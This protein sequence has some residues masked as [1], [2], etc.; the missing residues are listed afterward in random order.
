MKNKRE[1]LNIVK[2]KDL[3]VYKDNM[4]PTVFK[5][6]RK[7]VKHKKSLLAEV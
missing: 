4:R 3:R 5:D 1:K 6:K 7:R 2:C